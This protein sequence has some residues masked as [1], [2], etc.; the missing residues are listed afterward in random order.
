M[1]KIIKHP[2]WLTVLIL[3][4]C[5]TLIYIF[6]TGCSF[7][8]FVVFGIAAIT[9]AFLLLFCLRKRSKRVGSILLWIFTS[10]VIIGLIAAIFTGVLIGNAARGDADTQCDYIIILGAGVNGTVPSMSLQDRIDAAYDYL[11]ANPE[12]IGIV[13]GGQGPGEDISEAQCMAD[14]LASRGI[15]QERLWVEDRSTSTRENIAYSLA[16][17]EQRTGVRPKAAGI[18]SSEYHL[19]RAGLVAREQGLESVG[20]P[21]KTGWVTLRT[22]YF[23]REIA[24][25]WFYAISN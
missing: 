6:M 7:L 14:Q 18:L 24:A 12:C 19:Y 15:A 17:I 21:A 22:S 11:T 4:I 9:A 16:L 3:C 8:A 1:K 5:S 13:S 20:I 10:L 2:G 23:L 25:I